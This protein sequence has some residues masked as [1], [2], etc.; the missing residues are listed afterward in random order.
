MCLFTLI[1]TTGWYHFPIW[2]RKLKRTGYLKYIFSDVI[3]GLVL[4]SIDLHI[5]HH[6]LLV[7]SSYS[8]VSLA[9]IKL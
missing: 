2:L 3:P 8:A 4:F 5:L 9:C 7:C 1:F 6:F